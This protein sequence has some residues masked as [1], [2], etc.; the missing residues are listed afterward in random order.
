MRTRALLQQVRG[1]RS[2]VL[3]FLIA[4]ALLVH[5]APVSAQ[6]PICCACKA[7]G[8]S[9]TTCLTI[10]AEKLSAG[11]EIKSRNQ[12]YAPCTS[13]PKVV[14][15]SLNGWTCGESFGGAPAGS[16]LSPSRCMAAS[17]PGGVC[18]TGDPKDAY[19]AGGAPKSDTVAPAKT[20]VDVPIIPKLNVEIPGF[21]FT[22]SVVTEDTSSLLAQYIA[23][24]YR[25]GVSIAAIAATVMFTWGAFLYLLGSAIP[26]IHSGKNIMID[27]VFGMILVLGAH[28][29]LRTINPE[30][31]TL[32]TLYIKGVNPYAVGQYSYDAI[33]DQG[34]LE[35]LTG[36]P[37]NAEE[38]ILAG[39]KLVAGVDPCLILA[40][41]Q[42]ESALR[43][44]WSGQLSGGAPEKAHAWGPCQQGPQFLTASSYLTIAARRMF[45]DFPAPVVNGSA[46]ERIRMGQY[47]NKNYTAAGYIAALNIKYLM[48][49]SGGNELTA[50]AGYY[51]G[52]ESLRLWR[53]A[54]GCAPTPGTL[55]G[56]V[57]AA[58][59]CIPEYVAVISAGAA[60]KG[61]PEDRYVCPNAK[62]DNTAQFIG[63]CSRDGRRC[64]AARVGPYTRNLPNIY[65]RFA[66]RHSCAISTQDAVGT[67][68]P[69]QSQVGAAGRLKSGE[70]ILIIGDSLSQGLTG[71]L[72]GLAQKDSHAFSSGPG[73]QG[74]HTT[75]WAPGGAYNQRLTDGLAAKPS[76]VLIVLGTNDEYDA[77][78][79]QAVNT[80]I[81]RA[82][83]IISQVEASGARFYWIG[84]PLPLPFY[85]GR[86]PANLVTPALKSAIP[87]SQ[88]FPSESYT[89]PRDPTDRLHPSSAGYSQW[90][91]YIWTWLN[92]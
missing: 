68:T 7:P 3:G 62:Q 22:G 36:K 2:L 31:L 52:S 8:V 46:S 4:C 13:L 92:Q 85:N 41:C 5:A 42:T 19:T 48:R 64:Y 33:P 35:G 78:N 11:A 37:A 55:R 24:A 10:P 1:Q 17:T 60:P 20:S 34:Q 40:I 63:Q 89:I 28:M 6:T 61:C 79:P 53:K 29:L 32:D 56:G 80:V 81:Q 84:P 54:N 73:V 82:R 75:E 66:S 69:P 26:S 65:Q 16:P 39:A 71:P 86:D 51:S 43:P 14:G 91:G 25:F 67:V 57:S 76:V 77:R 47:L 87:S 49:A 44:L 15:D 38:M 58:D 88:Y 70:S 27:A 83:A 50:A 21:A 23:G 72:R 30:T 18:Q 59:A 45:P 12:A 74:S 9:E 90:S